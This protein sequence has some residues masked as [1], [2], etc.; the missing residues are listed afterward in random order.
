M[1]PARSELLGPHCYDLGWSW[2][3]PNHLVLC[4]AKLGRSRCGEALAALVPDPIGLLVM[5]TDQIAESWG[6]VADTQ[7]RT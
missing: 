5:P 4:M 6:N 7:L 3:V 2:Q 1:I